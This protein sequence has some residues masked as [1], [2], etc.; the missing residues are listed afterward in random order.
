MVSS[1]DIHN[2]ITRGGILLGMSVLSVPMLFASGLG[3]MQPKMKP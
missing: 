3:E 2:S 1:M